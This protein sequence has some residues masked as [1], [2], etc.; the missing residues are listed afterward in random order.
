MD[1]IQVPAQLVIDR[2]K[3]QVAEQAARIAILEAQTVMLRQ[4]ASGGES[5]D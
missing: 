1:E 2:L 3:S 4:Q 5:D